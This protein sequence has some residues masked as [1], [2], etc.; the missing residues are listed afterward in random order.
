MGGAMHVARQ[1]TVTAEAL[2][3][4]RRGLGLESEA[5]AHIQECLD[6]AFLKG[7]ELTCQC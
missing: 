6:A 4:A 7:V 3:Q 1:T 5:V 2:D